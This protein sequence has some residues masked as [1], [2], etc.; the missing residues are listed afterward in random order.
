L[1]GSPPSTEPGPLWDYLFLNMQFSVGNFGLGL[2][3]LGALLFAYGE[4]ESMN[5]FA[6][7]TIAGVGLAASI[8]LWMNDFGFR[9]EVEAARE[10]LR[11]SGQSRF[12]VVDQTQAWR[13]AWPWK[14]VY[15]SASR[16]GTYFNAVFALVWVTLIL[17][18]VLGTSPTTLYYLDALGL[19]VS[20]VVWVYSRLSDEKRRFSRIPTVG[21]E[22]SHG[23]KPSSAAGPT[24]A[25]PPSGQPP[26]NPVLADREPPSA[27]DASSPGG[28]PPRS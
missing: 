3:G 18:G 9:K 28:G 14:Y 19:F 25:N 21:L 26:A 16:L 1:A 15:L 20:G 23:C 12:A 8:V 13:R 22:E 5:P 10:L 11:N 24:I 17:R 6:G 2:T 27:A 7:N 4:V